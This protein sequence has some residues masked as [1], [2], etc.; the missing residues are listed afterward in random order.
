M[1]HSFHNLWLVLDENGAGG[2]WYE[3]GG[4]NS[5]TPRLFHSRAA[6]QEHARAC[7]ARTGSMTCVFRVRPDGRLGLGREVV[8]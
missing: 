2:A 8:A 5:G 1:S 6:A 4:I 7:A 3:H